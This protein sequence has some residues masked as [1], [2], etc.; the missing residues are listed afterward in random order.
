MV[1]EKKRDKSEQH[2]CNDD[3]S[4]GI[5]VPQCIFIRVS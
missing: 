2:K 1:V 3:V 4:R 5:V